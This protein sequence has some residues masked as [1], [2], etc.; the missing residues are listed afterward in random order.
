MLVSVHFYKTPGNSLDHS[1]SAEPGLAVF[2]HR[3]QC[4]DNELLRLRLVGGLEMSDSCSQTQALTVLHK[5]PER[6]VAVVPSPTSD[7]A[8]VLVP[9]LAGRRASDEIEVDFEIIIFSL[10]P[11]V[12][13]GMDDQCREWKWLSTFTIPWKRG[14][15]GQ[16]LSA[17]VGLRL[18]QEQRL[19]VRCVCPGSQE[20]RRD[21]GV[22][23]VTGHG[24]HDW[25]VSS[26]GAIGG[27]CVHAVTAEAIKDTTCTVEAMRQSQ[28][29]A[30]EMPPPLLLQVMK[31]SRLLFYVSQSCHTLLARKT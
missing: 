22:L 11:T 29:P 3:S 20:Q 17:A 27:L 7:S 15:P 8:A 26:H 19:A 25:T 30:E 4:P 13:S 24:H 28:D 10:A 16:R 9:F 21:Q 18:C 5:S 31:E 23:T 12:V 14:N 1:S 6:L 2:R